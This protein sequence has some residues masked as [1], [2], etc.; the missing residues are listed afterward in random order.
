MVLFPNKINKYSFEIKGKKFDWNYYLVA[1]AFILECLSVCVCVCVLVQLFE[2]DYGVTA[3]D[4]AQLE[5]SEEVL[6]KAVAL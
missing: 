2:S 1:R 3:V 4:R 5:A 6:N